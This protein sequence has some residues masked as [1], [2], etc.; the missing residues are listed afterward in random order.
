VTCSQKT[1]PNIQGQNAV[2][3]TRQANGSSTLTRLIV[4][5]NSA[6]TATVQS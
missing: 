1:F 2:T 4:I 6:N 3:L 5:G